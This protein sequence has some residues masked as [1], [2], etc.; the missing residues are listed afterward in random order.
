[1]RHYV[2][3]R[4]AYG[5]EWSREAIR[6]RLDVTR[7]VTVEMMARQT[8]DWTWVIL[9]D[10]RDPLRFE[11]IETFRAAEVEV[12]VMDW[13]RP[14]VLARA[15]W[16][17]RPPRAHKFEQIAATAYGAPW[18]TQTGEPDDTVLMTRLDDDDA[19]TATTLAR[20]QARAAGLTAR[21]V[22][23]HPVGYRVFNRR[24]SLVRHE[25]NA[26]QT[27]VTPPGDTA[28]VYD[29]GHTV[30]RR[31]APV[32]V[33]DEQPAW[34]WARHRDTISGWKLADKPFSADLER[35]FPVDWSVL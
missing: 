16:D 24:C 32:V 13:Q 7:A 6:R 26:M 29:Y 10:P 8:V 17:R 28:S 9:V 11:R 21:T 25:S 33:V 18:R 19:L 15:P 2:F 1:V 30:A 12:I 35:L 20:V 34:L 31:F 5:P 22:L 27:L 23:M 3:T 14:P 4:S